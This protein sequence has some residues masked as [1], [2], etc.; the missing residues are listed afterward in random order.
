MTSD[1]EGINFYIYMTLKNQL[2]RS[3]SKRKKKIS[4]KRI[5]RSRNYRNK[6]MMGG[7]YLESFKPLKI[8]DLTGLTVSDDLLSSNKFKYYLMML[9]IQFV[10]NEETDD[11]YYSTWFSFFDVD[12]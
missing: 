12:F 1:T 11:E 10:P 4:R 5:L 7:S 9:Y 6:G 8:L 3:N 2:R